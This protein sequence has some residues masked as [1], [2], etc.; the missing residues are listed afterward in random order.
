M[1]RIVIAALLLC[2]SVATALGTAEAQEAGSGKRSL[3]V[4]FAIGEKFVLKKIGFT[5]FGNE[6]NELPMGAWRLDDLVIDKVN[7][8]LGNRYAVW[9]IDY[10]KG[11]LSEPRDA[12]FRLFADSTQFRDRVRKV[13]AGQQ[14]DLYL[15]VTNSLSKF[16][17]TNQVITGIGLVEIGGGLGTTHLYALTNVTIFD[18][19]TLEIVR[20]E[21]TSIG[22]AT[23]LATI[24]G[25]HR[26]VPGSA[27]PKSKDLSQNEPLRR[28]TWALV[29]QSLD[30]TV[31]ALF[32]AK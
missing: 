14:C 4:I 7:A 25:P 2:G 9:R 26:E 10:P 28:A 12:G 3:C 23:F 8:L 22:Q 29:E 19:H 24:V 32:A 27:W 13:V 16:G 21:P 20:D 30:R 6:E 31:P 5:V 1:F 18:G 17:T 15:V 11:A